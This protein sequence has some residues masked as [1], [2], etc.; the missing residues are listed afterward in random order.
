MIESVKLIECPRDAWQGLQRQIPT[1]RKVEYLRGLISAGFRHIDAVSFVS[2]KAVPQMADSEQVL[3]QLGPHDGVEIIGIVV[4]EKGAERAIATGRVSTL[5]YPYSIS[6]TFLRRNQNQSPA[7]NEAVL[8]RI[9]DRADQAA[10]LTT[11]AYISMAFGNPYGDPWSE[12]KLAEAAKII[13][14]MGI[15]SISIADT[16][17]AATPEQ[18]HRAVAAISRD[19]G[20]IGVHLHST[21]A[22]AMAKVLAAYDAGCRRFD[23]AMGGL[24][25]CPFAQDELVGNVP[26]EEVLRALEQRGVK[27]EV[28]RRLPAVAAI[29][30]E[31]GHE[32][33]E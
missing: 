14:A 7:E 22:G 30:A 21:P 19:G 10:G 3:E 26:T 4:N 23:A 16:V 13:A 17:G 32:F 2:P 12:K 15:R 25:G 6:E 28:E 18:V 9:K 11:V 1:E 29:N 27:L 31:I 24:G 33:S 8:K 20:E 5:G